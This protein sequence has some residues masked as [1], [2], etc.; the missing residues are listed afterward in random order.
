MACHSRELGL[1]ESG[2]CLCSRL[3]VNSLPYWHKLKYNSTERQSRTH[4]DKRNKV[5]TTKYPI[6]H[7][8]DSSSNYIYYNLPKKLRAGNVFMCLSVHRGMSYVII[9]HDALDLPVQSQ[10]CDMRTPPGPTQT[11]T[12]FWT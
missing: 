5:K 12:P 3:T 1:Q 6:S 10:T 2:Y 4:Q 9:N 7:L 8:F 11:L